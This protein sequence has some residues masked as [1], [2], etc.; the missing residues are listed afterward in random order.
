M[1]L[2]KI[3][4][5]PLFPVNIWVLS[6]YLLYVIV[7]I[8][9]THVN[10]L[11]ISSFLLWAVFVI[12]PLGLVGLRLFN[13]HDTIEHHTRC[14]L[15]F[16]FGVL[17]LPFVTVV[18]SI[19]I[20]SR[21]YLCIFLYTLSAVFLVVL[22]LEIRGGIKFT[23]QMF[24]AIPLFFALLH[25]VLL[26]DIFPR[27]DDYGVLRMGGLGADTMYMT[28][29]QQI[30]RMGKLIENPWYAGM[31][32]PKHHFFSEYLLASY[33]LTFGRNADIFQVRLMF[34]FILGLPLLLGLTFM[35]LHK[36]ICRKG[37]VVLLML[38]LVLPLTVY[39]FGERWS[40]L[41]GMNGFWVLGVHQDLNYLFGLIIFLC[42]VFCVIYFLEVSALEVR[43]LIL[44]QVAMAFSTQFKVNFSL[45]YYPAIQC[46][47]LGY[48][49]LK[50]HIRLAV[51]GII[52]SVCSIGLIYFILDNLSQGYGGR[53]FGLEYGIV[54][55]EDFMPVLQANSDYGLKPFLYLLG[56]IPS[57]L[58]PIGVIMIYTHAYMP[59]ISLWLLWVGIFC[60]KKKREPFDVFLL[61]IYITCLFIVL[62]VI[63]ESKWKWNLAGHLHYLIPF[64][65]LFTAARLVICKHK[66]I[67][68]ISKGVIICLLGLV[69]PTMLFGEK[70]FRSPWKKGHI[71]D[72]NL[73]ALCKDIEQETPRDA[74]V[75]ACRKQLSILDNQAIT[76]L[77]NRSRMGPGYFVYTSGYPDVR[78]RTHLRRQLSELHN[79]EFI[80]RDIRVNNSYLRNRRFFVIGKYCDIKK[81]H[82]IA[83][84]IKK[85][86]DYW[87]AELKTYEEEQAGL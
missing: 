83:S 76:I 1:T 30:A 5:R 73:V 42:M 27:V 9:R 53:T 6:A 45:A 41:V 87:Y 74:I 20:S 59:L 17:S 69:I 55:M 21:F 75:L 63:E 31:P 14:L 70:A 77:C 39:P 23:S 48:Y 66:V 12:Y 65:G 13:W 85:F 61:L 64:L 22:F 4:R 15:A 28:L 44:L 57:V 46:V 3:H 60:C 26:P 8:C 80:L 34:H 54:A 81:N 37:W 68:L 2:L 35:L 47:L 16:A 51:I 32:F 72:S 62:F 86:D 11:T 50:K 71:V 52:S 33:L 24:V 29:G 36:L 7:F 79:P 18:S 56:L 82:D 19:I 10:I 49:L 67:R 38:C 40:G 84:K 78:E 25:I 43:T 58:K